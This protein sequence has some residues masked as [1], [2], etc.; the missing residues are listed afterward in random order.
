MV[1]IF[2][3]YVWRKKPIIVK[4]SLNRVRDITYIN[5]CVKVLTESVKNNR[6]KKNEIMN[7]SSGQKFTVKKLSKSFLLLNVSISIP[8]LKYFSKLGIY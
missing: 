6:L 1:S 7:L 3:S 2:S 5:D 4:G 8:I